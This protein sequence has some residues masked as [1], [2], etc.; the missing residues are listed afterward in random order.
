[1]ANLS[2]SHTA[3]AAS[4]TASELPLLSTTLAAFALQ[5]GA[6]RASR[7]KKGG[8]AVIPNRPLSV[9]QVILTGLV[10]PARDPKRI[11]IPSDQRESR[12]RANTKGA[13]ATSPRRPWL[14]IEFVGEA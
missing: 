11:V 10:H 14:Q 6:L 3:P 12:G 4:Q 2:V 13:A 7:N 5:E 8:S 9:T 1:M